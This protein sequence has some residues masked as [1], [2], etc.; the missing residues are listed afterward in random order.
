MDSALRV[1]IHN[2]F[3]FLQWKQRNYSNNFSD[4]ENLIVHINDYGNFTKLSSKC[5]SYAKS[6]AKAYTVHLWQDIA[7]NE[8]LIDGRSTI[9][10]VSCDLL[11]FKYTSCK[12]ETLSLSLLYPNNLLNSFLFTYFPSCCDTPLCGCGSGVQLLFHVVFECN[13]SENSHNTINQ[14][15]DTCENVIDCIMVTENLSVILL[16][17]SRSAD[18]FPLLISCVTK[19]LHYLKRSISIVS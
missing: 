19:C 7:T 12:V 5:C 10:T 9:P 17:L 2:V 4:H 8:Y 11:N 3:K 18:F 6:V 13:C 16:N 15:I 14:L 1:K